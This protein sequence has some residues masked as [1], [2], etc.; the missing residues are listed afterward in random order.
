MR[1]IVKTWWPLAA[2][3]LLMGLEGPAIS[4]VIAR[5]ANPKINL[6]A[7]GGV[8]FPLALFVEA[9]IIMLLAASTALCRDWESYR[10]LR[11]YMHSLS[12]GLTLLHVAI[13]FTPLYDLIVGRA[14]QAPTEI[15]EPARIGLMITLPW[16]WSI[17][18]RRFNQGVLIRFGHSLAVGAGTLVRLS[19]DGLVLAIGYLVGSV[20]GI[21]VASTAIVVGVLFEALYVGIR[22]RPVLRDQLKPASPEPR[23]LTLRA[24]LRFYVPLSLT[25][26]IFL[27]ARPIVS[28]GISRMPGALESLAAWPVVTALTFLLRSFGVS[29]NEVVIALL[30]EPRS[31]PNLRR[32]SLLLSGLTTGTLLVVAATPLSTFWFKGVSGLAAPLVILAR[33]SLWFALPLPAL[34]ALQSWYQGVIL[35]SRRTRCITEAVVIYLIV[36]N[37][38]I[39]AS[40]AWGA[41][42]GIYVGLIG[43]SA[44]ELLRTCWLAWRSRHARQAVWSRDELPLPS[45]IGLIQ[46]S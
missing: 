22:V 8:V 29:Y 25:S 37:A 10:K 40:V 45:S 14:I 16:T 7:Y 23:S 15:I 46:D 32:F 44:G 5:L 31:S 27:A 12:A 1:R 34:N 19:A 18:Y 6:A 36:L 30:D 21:I 9:P 41:I 26:L 20:P 24:F 11:V 35:H 3:W 43:L 38:V 13:A 2:S 28:A 33:T 17:A 42:T 4:A 39:W